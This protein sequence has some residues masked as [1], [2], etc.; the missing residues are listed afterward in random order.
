MKVHPAVNDS[1]SG[2]RTLLKDK[3]YVAL[4]QQI[5]TD[6]YPPGS[7]LAER[8]LAE[9]LGMSKTP[10]KAALERLELEGY[11]TIAP[12]QFVR[13]REL[14]TAD[15][16]EQYEIRTALETY[17]VRRLAGQLTDAQRERIASNL[18]LQRELI[19][20]ENLS[21]RVTADAQFHL[22]LAEVLG[23]QSIL[24]MMSELQ[25]RIYRVI[26]RIFRRTPERYAECVQEHER[27]AQAVLAGD[28]DRAAELVID[29]LQHGQKISLA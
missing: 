27:I 22:L 2:G 9:D 11:I 17:I 28:S 7:A 21:E 25:D 3:A 18:R 13:V 4:K 5:L 12:Q 23:N 29:H 8:K 1:S 14:D 24:R 15:I 26:T 6:R 19:E 20:R 16:A 10:V